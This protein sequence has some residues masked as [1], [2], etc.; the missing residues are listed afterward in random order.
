MKRLLLLTLANLAV[1]FVLSLVAH[2]FGL[3]ALLASHGVQMQGLL[4]LAGALGFG[5]SLISL[6]LSKWSA[7]NLLGVEVIADPVTV[8]QRWLFASVRRHAARVGVG[9]PEIGIFESAEMNAF[10][11][12]ANRNRALVAVS[13]G[14]LAGMTADEAEAVLGHE[15]TH[16]GN[17]DMVTMALL[18]GVVNTFVIFLA[19]MLGTVLDGALSGTRQ[20]QRRSPG[21]FYFVI[22]IVLQLLLG[23][24]ANMIVMWFSRHREFRAD[25]GG[26][27]LAGTGNMIA[28]LERLAEQHNGALP[29]QL[30]A[31]GICG[32]TAAGIQ[33]LFMSHPPVAERIAAL[34]DA[35]RR[36]LQGGRGLTL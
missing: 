18:Q 10:A 34:R 20:E 25:A 19:R 31:F 5:G 21:P 36:E 27:V 15:M 22:V 4:V 7:R 32:S 9:M 14:L 26:A 29:A 28:A 35:A 2:A 24:L 8:P 13:T 16:V 11:T 33:R 3:D 1:L 23:I 30:T 17:G 12:G 6:A